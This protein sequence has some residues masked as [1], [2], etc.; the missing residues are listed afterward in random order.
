MDLVGFWGFKEL[1][2]RKIQGVELVRLAEDFLMF[3]IIFSFSK[4]QT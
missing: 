4:A 1:Y 2:M 3:S